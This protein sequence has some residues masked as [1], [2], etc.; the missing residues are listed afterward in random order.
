MTSSAIFCHFS[1]G[2]N[3][4]LAAHKENKKVT[5]YEEIII[6]TLTWSW[7]SQPSVSPNS[8]FFCL[9]PLSQ[10]SLPVQV[11]R[12][13]I[14]FW[15]DRSLT[16]SGCLFS[17]LHTIHC[18]RTNSCPPSQ[19]LLAK[20]MFGCNRVAIKI[21]FCPTFAEKPYVDHGYLLLPPCVSVL[22]WEIRMFQTGFRYLY[23]YK[24]FHEKINTCNEIF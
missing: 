3:D 13:L 10:H 7:F 12:A 9:P 20:V 19:K 11:P 23:W 22:W 2:V 15:Y 16:S 6:N 21:P 24:K 14:R 17:T 1:G 18:H 8:F 4:N 5:A